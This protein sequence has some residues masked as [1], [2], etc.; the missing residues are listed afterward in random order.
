MDSLPVAILVGVLIAAS[1]FVG[2]FLQ[3]RLAAHH[4]AERS[5]DM[6]GGV[7]GLLTLLLAL[8][9]GLLI[10]TAY[11]VHSTQQTELQTI[12][13]RALEFDLE[14]RQYGP[15]GDPGRELLRRDLV[16]AHE[17]FWGD[18][19][20]R[21]QAYDAS[22]KA[23]SDLSTFFNGLDPKTPAQKELLTAARGNYHFIGEQ[24][25]LMSMQASTPIAWPLI[26]AVT[27][28]SCLMFA[29]M[30]LLSKLN[31]MAAA[32]VILGA[33]SVGVAIFL[34][35]EF[36]QPYTSSIRV[37]PVALEQA[38]VRLDQPRTDAA[39]Q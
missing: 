37:S 28:W 14:M 1:G 25:L 31:P 7:V 12:A 36:N 9:L 3:R 18:D 27:F 26:Y 10:W 30:G 4:T 11:G 24:R 39:S 34:I 23:M 2:L 16:W 29:G 20:S 6:I 35:L 19:V 8:T 21:A 33:V 32:I 15:E 38:I 5:R 13:A 17:Q 22:Y